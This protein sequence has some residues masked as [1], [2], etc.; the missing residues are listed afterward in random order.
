[1]CCLH[2]TT[3]NLFSNMACPTL[4]RHNSPACAAI[5][6]FLYA[7]LTLFNTTLEYCAMQKHIWVCDHKYKRPHGPTI[8]RGQRRMLFIQTRFSVKFHPSYATYSP[9]NSCT[10]HGHVKV[11]LFWYRLKCEHQVSKS[12]K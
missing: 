11:L 4:K 7:L 6:Q 10:A 9:F 5:Q 12:V 1:M 8:H 3:I 2:F